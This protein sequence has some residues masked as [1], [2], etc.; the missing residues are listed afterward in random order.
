MMVMSVTLIV[1]ALAFV[2]LDFLWLG[3]VV[4]DFN[5]RQLAEIGRI[6]DGDFQILYSPAIA[7]YVLMAIGVVVFVLPQAKTASFSGAFLLGALLGF[8][9]Y[10]VFDMTNMA[11]LR[12]YPLAFAFAD[13]AWGTFVFGMVT[14]ITKWVSERIAG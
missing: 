4:K 6:V 12:N 11:I 7:T 1:A 14:V 10:G 13:M 9:V 8:V 3:F 5:L 2:V